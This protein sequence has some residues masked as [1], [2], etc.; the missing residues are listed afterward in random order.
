[1]PIVATQGGDL[2]LQLNLSD[3]DT[4]DDEIEF[5]EIRITANEVDSYDKEDIALGGQ[6]NPDGSI[7]FTTNV[8]EKLH[9]AAM[10]CQELNPDPKL[11]AED[12]EEEA[13]DTRPGANGW[14]TSDN[15]AQFMDENGNF[16]MPEGATFINGDGDHEEQE[17]GEE[18]EQEPLG[19]FQNLDAS[20]RVTSTL[21]CTEDRGMRLDAVNTADIAG[22]IGPGAGTT[23]TAAEAVESGTLDEVDRPRPS[24]S[25]T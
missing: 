19:A 17:E 2:Y 11:A 9:K 18:E 23:R 10:A 13:E 22:L 24:G 7:K 25:G 21:S 12:G 15:M 16:Q 20:A 1:M 6:I 5:M 4:P 14:I 3:E 8:V